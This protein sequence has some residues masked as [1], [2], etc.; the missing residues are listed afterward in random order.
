MAKGKYRY[1]TDSLTYEKIEYSPRRIIMMGLTYLS[2]IFVVGFIFMFTWLHFFPSTREQALID[3]N[4][5]LRIQ[6]Q[7][8]NNRM[9]TVQNVLADIANRDNNIY[10]IIFETDPIP[11]EIRTAGYGGVN[12]YAEL[13]A[14]PNMAIAVETSKRLDKLYKM[15]YI[16]SLSFDSVIDLAK[17]KEKMLRCIPAIQPL[18]GKDVKRMASGF[19]Y[20]IHPVYKTVKF[21][22]GVDLTASTGTKIYATGDGVVTLAEYNRGYGKMVK[23]NHGYN[24]ETAYGHMSM[25]LVK[26]GQKIKRGDVIGLVGNTGTSTGP[27]VHYEVRKH[28]RPVNPVNYYLNDL[29]PEEFDEVLK[30]SLHPTQSFD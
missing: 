24:Y 2:V 14:K 12:R 8:I 13:E 19:G 9:G 30:V 4:N 5:E 25:I 27:H 7:H 28:G 10:R 23:I 16:Q 3:E 17:N 1:N 6:Y 29:T 18:S 22:D 11:S 21:H 20:R 15:L 26:K